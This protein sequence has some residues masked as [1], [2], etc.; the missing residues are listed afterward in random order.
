MNWAGVYDES[1]KWSN[2]LAGYEKIASG[3][4]YIWGITIPKLRD[5]IFVG[6]GPDTFPV[7]IGRNGSD[8]ALKINAGE[9]GITYL[10]P[11][12]YYLQ[13]GIETGVISLISILTFFAVYFI[14][15]VK[16]YFFR[17][18][19]TQEHRIG[20]ACML[21]AIGFLICG[22]ANDSLINVTPM[23]WCILGI[24]IVINK[25]LKEDKS[26]VR[27]IKKRI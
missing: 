9:F 11:H 26:N 10:R 14:D 12:N 23:F 4:G 18:I 2:V 20:F 16:I 19:E 17:R 22:L 27:S 21:S 7:A 1:V 24:G 3:R 25:R 15:C 6:S 8:Y 5:Y 13:M